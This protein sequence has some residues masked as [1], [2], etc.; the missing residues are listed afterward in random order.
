MSLAN[1][2]QVVYIGKKKKEV[3]RGR[4]LSYLQHQ[5]LK[6]LEITQRSLSVPSLSCFLDPSA[7]EVL[8]LLVEYIHARNKQINL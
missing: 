2:L 4:H 3:E 5:K 7:Q 6:Q 1:Y 8:A